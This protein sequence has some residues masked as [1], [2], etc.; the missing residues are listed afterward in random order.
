MADD[1]KREKERFSHHPLLIRKKKR[2]F[3]KGEGG[4]FRN[5]EESSKRNFVYR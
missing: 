4:N 2:V 5:E 1:E 3:Q